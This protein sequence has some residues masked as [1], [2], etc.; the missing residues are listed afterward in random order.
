MK[1]GTFSVLVRLYLFVF[2]VLMIPAFVFGVPVI[3]NFQ[4][5]SCLSGSYGYVTPLVHVEVQMTPDSC[6]VAVSKLVLFRL[7]FVAVLNGVISIFGTIITFFVLA[8]IDASTSIESEDSKTPEIDQYGIDHLV[9]HMISASRGDMSKV[10]EKLGRI[11]KNH[12]QRSHFI[13]QYVES[14]AVEDRDAAVKRLSL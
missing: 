14:L 7:V 13:E 4:L 8:L 11:P 6:A 1:S 2:V 3:K 5:A 9:E 10:E 12:P